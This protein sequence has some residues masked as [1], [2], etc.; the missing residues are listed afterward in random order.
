MGAGLRKGPTRY[1]LRLRPGHTFRDVAGC[2][3]PSSEGARMRA[4]GIGS[5]ATMSS[6]DNVVVGAIQAM[7]PSLFL[8][9]TDVL[10]TGPQRTERGRHCDQSCDQVLLSSTLGS[11]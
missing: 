6:G 5:V 11:Y 10:P 7:L 4:K 1:G 9:S 3:M 2:S 8:N